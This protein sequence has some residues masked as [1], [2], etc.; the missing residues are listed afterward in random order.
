MG[1]VQDLALIQLSDPSALAALLAPRALLLVERT[2]D[3]EHETVHEVKAL[4]VTGIELARPV[5]PLGRRTG[6]WSQ[7]VPSITRA[8]FGWEGET[9][10]PLWIDVLADVEVDLVVETDAAGLDSLVVR[11]VDDYG[12]LAEFQSR[13]T[14]LDLP[15]FMAS[16]GLVTVEDLKEAGEYLR[17]EVRM[18]HPPVFDPGDPANLR[19]A[20]L[21]AAVLLGDRT[22]VGAALRAARSVGAAA[23]DSPLPPGGLGVRTAAHA[24]VC[25]FPASAP[26]PPPAP[27]QAQI[28]ALLTGAGIAPLFLT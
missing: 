4:R 24:P 2:H 5:H 8:D 28:D 27:T 25:A 7:V 12:T 10:T 16:H 18:R 1:A 11:A 13:F 19:T 22:D 14:T 23:R 9:A 6:Y 17:A 20:R 21:A 3:L 15:A 26:P